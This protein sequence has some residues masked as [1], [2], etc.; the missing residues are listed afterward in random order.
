MATAVLVT[1][2]A[3]GV[4]LLR[5]AS[6]FGIS[7]V[8]TVLRHEFDLPDYPL[9]M[10]S[11]PVPERARE[12]TM[13]ASSVIYRSLES[14]FLY[15]QAPLMPPKRRIY[16]RFAPWCI[17]IAISRTGSF[18]YHAPS[19]QRYFSISALRCPEAVYDDVG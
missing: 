5:S 15:F 4:F 11:S 19:G 13:H 3:L 9:H 6:N 16:G 7:E 12:E 10:C 8:A 18:G 17:V 14:R 1:T 2:G